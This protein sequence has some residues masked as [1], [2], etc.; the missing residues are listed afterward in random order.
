[1]N[2]RQRENIERIGFVVF[3]GIFITIVTS[4]IY[5]MLPDEFKELLISFIINQ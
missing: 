1:M 2:R 5:I 3:M 4:G